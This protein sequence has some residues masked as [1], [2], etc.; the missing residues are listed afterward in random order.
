M[1]KPMEENRQELLTLIGSYGIYLEEL[2]LDI[3]ITEN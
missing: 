2:I 3:L 1:L